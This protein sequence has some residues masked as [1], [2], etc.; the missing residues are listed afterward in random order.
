MKIYQEIAKEPNRYY[1]NP[2]MIIPTLE[3]LASP[4]TTLSD[5]LEIIETLL[6]KLKK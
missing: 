6:K 4:D 2:T 3:N 5:A 1:E